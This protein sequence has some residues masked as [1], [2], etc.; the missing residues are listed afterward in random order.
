MQPNLF[1]CQNFFP[2]KVIDIQKETADTVSIA[3]DIP[4][5]LKPDFKYKN[6][7]YVT[8][9]VSVNQEELRRSYSLSSCSSTESEF[10]IAVK[11]IENGRVSGFLNDSLK[12]ADT[13]EISKPEG[14]FYFE[15]N[16]ETKS[17][18]LFAAGS[19]ITPII[20]ILK[21]ALADNDNSRV[22]L[23]YGNR[24]EDSIIYKK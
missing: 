20:S 15:N 21:G 7:Q 1:T 23:L 14:N 8:L 18:V 17:V 12:E 2:V 22:V 13:L 24:N 19:G 4:G 11:K 9:K 6:G 16:G 5:D 10:R 3:F